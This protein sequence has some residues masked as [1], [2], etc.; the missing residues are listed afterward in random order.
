[1]K[2]SSMSFFQKKNDEDPLEHQNQ[3][4][5]PA[6]AALSPR[7]D[8]CLGIRWKKEHC[9]EGDR[10]SKTDDVKMIESEPLAREIHL[11]LG[12]SYF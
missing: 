5:H 8:V 6:A 10:K 11:H 7:K 2:S 3:K 1:M 9:E 12:L 4:K